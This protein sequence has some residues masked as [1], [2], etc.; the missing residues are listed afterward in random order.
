MQ[1]LW[2]HDG[3]L[4][5]PVFLVDFNIT[6]GKSLSRRI[7]MNLR[8]GER[9]TVWSSFPVSRSNL[10]RFLSSLRMKWQG[11]KKKFISQSFCIY[12][13]AYMKCTMV[14]RWEEIIFKNFEILK[15][16]PKLSLIYLTKHKRYLF[17]YLKPIL[18]EKNW[19]ENCKNSLFAIN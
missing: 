1:F 16:W 4:Q 10:W 3:I 6:F 12:I 19:F 17:F 9:N 15:F 2:L 11:L 7:S 18:Y 13:K 5:N 14:K 8:L